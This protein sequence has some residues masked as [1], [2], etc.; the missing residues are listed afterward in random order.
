MRNRVGKQIVFVLLALLLVFGVATSAGAEVYTHEQVSNNVLY[1]KNSGEYSGYSLC[2]RFSSGTGTQAKIYNDKDDEVWD[3]ISNITNPNL[4]LENGN[5][6]IKKK[7]YPWSSWSSAYKFSVQIFDNLTVSSNE[8]NAVTV[9]SVPVVAGTPLTV[10]VIRDQSANVVVND[11]ANKVKTIVT[12]GVNAD[13][14][15]EVKLTAD[16]SI[17]VVYGNPPA[18]IKT[19]NA[20]GAVVKI[21]G[22]DFDNGA[23]KSYLEGES[24]TVTVEEPADNTHILGVQVTNKAGEEVANPVKAVS[25]EQY[26]ITVLTEKTELKTKTNPAYLL[27]TVTIAGL[28]NLLDQNASVPAIDS[29]DNVKVELYIDKIEIP[30]AG[31]R[32]INTYVNTDY[33][34]LGYNVVEFFLNNLDTDS[35]KVRYTYFPSDLLYGRVVLSDVTVYLNEKTCITLEY[36][37]QPFAYEATDAEI[38]EGVLKAVET[39]Y[40]SQTWTSVDVDAAMASGALTGTVNRTMNEDG[41]FTVTV[42]YNDVTETVNVKIAAPT[43]TV[44]AGSGDVTF[45]FTSPATVEA[46]KEYTVSAE[47]NAKQNKYIQEIEVVD[48]GGTVVAAAKT[49]N[50]V[51]FTPANKGVYTVNVTVGDTW[52]KTKNNGTAFVG[53]NPTKDDLLTLVDL[54]NSFPKGINLNDVDAEIYVE[55]IEVF[56]RVIDIDSYVAWGEEFDIP[57]IGK[58][59]PIEIYLETVKP[60]SLTIRFIYED[61]NTAVYA[62]IVSDSFVLSLVKEKAVTQ[63]NLKSEDV[64]LT[65]SE[66]LDHEDIFNAIFDSVTAGEDVVNV[67]YGQDITVQGTIKAGEQSF[68]V[69]YAGN[70]DYTASTASKTVSITKGTASVDVVSKVVKYGQVVSGMIEIN[71]AKAAYTSFYVGL[72]AAERATV[73]HLNLPHLVDTEG[74]NN[75]IPN[76]GDLVAGIEDRFEGSVSLAQLGK[77]LSDIMDALDNIGDL[78]TNIDTDSLSMLV[79]VLNQVAD[80]EGVGDVV[81]ELSFGD[82][83]LPTD[84]GAYLVGAVVSDANYNTAADLGYLVIKPNAKQVELA[85]NIVDENGIITRE[86]ILSGDY[87][88]GSHVKQGDLTEEQLTS[89]EKK[90]SN[91]YA[92]VTINGEY[93]VG[94]KP[95]AEVGAYTQIAYLLDLG[96]EMFYAVPIARAYVVVADTVDMWFVDENGSKN[97]ERL[98]TYDGKGKSMTAVAYTKAGEKLPTKDITYYYIGIEGDAEG[99]YAKNPSGSKLPTEAGVY[100]V[101]ATYINENQSLFGVTAGAMVIQPA[102]AEIDV[103]NKL[104]NYTG[105]QVSVTDMIDKDPDDAAATIIVASVNVAGDFSEDGFSALEDYVNFDLP[106]RMDNVIKQIIPNAYEY[107]VSVSTVKS[108][109]KEA[110]GM[111]GEADVAQIK[112]L[113]ELLNKIDNSVTLTFKETKNVDTKD[114]G[115]YLV[116]GAITDPNYCFDADAGLLVIAPNVDTA[117]LKWNYTDSNGIITLPK[118]DAIDMGATAY[119]NNGEAMNELTRKIDYIYI[120]VDEKGESVFVKNPA[121]LGNGLYT[122]IAYIYEKE[123]SANMWVVKPIMRQVLIVTQTVDVKVIDK[124]VNYDGN[125]HAV[126]VSVKTKD[127]SAVDYNSLTV[128]YT[129]LNT[130]SAYHSTSAP[131]EVGIY[132]VVATYEVRNNNGDVKYFGMDAGVLTIK[133]VTSDVDVVYTEVAYDG[134]EKMATIN[135]ADGLN[136][137]KVVVDSENNINIILPENVYSGTKTFDVSGALTSVEQE[138]KNLDK[139]VLDTLI[140][141]IQKINSKVGTLSI[142]GKQPVEVGTYTVYA[143]AYAANTMPSYD[144]DRLVITGETEATATPAPTDGTATPAPTDGTATPAPADPDATPTTA[145]TA[146]TAPEAPATAAP[147]D[148]PTATPKPLPSTGDQSH[149]ALWMLLMIFSGAALL[150]VCRKMTVKGR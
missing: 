45:N 127:G 36:D 150:L 27:D 4:T 77:T 123:V 53:T 16:A 52:L 121:S 69:K 63:V 115:M 122:E 144:F 1:L 101:I 95:S 39:S 65:F 76:L 75:L 146:T 30:V 14:L 11:I 128:T 140:A 100:T 131:K 112:E 31:E 51:T 141:V 139:D 72:N 18:E 25:G 70:D 22:V 129:G 7:A 74:L 110:L 64:T 68:T 40:D 138:L 130:D 71:P 124:T 3:S 98:Y 88:L 137:I 133:P 116:I 48:Q 26:T 89:A 9:N 21:N 13:S 132:S 24:F 62:P 15:P 10:S 67:T 37:N 143:I 78:P 108:K 102:E 136:L 117:E 93:Y 56:G 84:A 6:Y 12:D 59:N 19:C 134:T 96:N 118:L 86:A 41:T 135:A 91:V 29:L 126:D 111:L 66:N 73:V 33:K 142:N 60:E 42:T 5:Y 119:N 149:N 87:D 34:I 8:S 104:V 80:L 2:T 90:L 43:A 38:I 23:V 106:T 28:K 148:A 61:A 49:A 47:L 35:V 57:L 97:D 32:V 44:K 17:N 20:N 83:N 54:E 109:L 145:P 58:I 81:I 120:G 125:R 105:K 99:Y 94:N 85:F 113:Q 103:T 50:T 55:A 79:D 114:I 147:S 92:G 82:Y 46:N 107:G